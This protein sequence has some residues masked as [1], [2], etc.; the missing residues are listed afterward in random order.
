MIYDFKVK[1]IDGNYVTLDK[2]KGKIMLIVNTA[3]RCG[4]SYQ[5]KELETIYNKYS[6][7]LAILSFPSNQF[8]NQE[9]LNDSEIKEFCSLNHNVTYD[10]FAKIDVNGINEDPLYTYLKN[11][12]RGFLSKDIKWNFTKFLVD[13]KGNVV[14]RFASNVSPYDIEK[15]I[16]KLI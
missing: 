4:F 3:T 6:N 15:Y 1:T 16:E 8:N 2:Y 11:K 12:K 10:T 9:P 5:Y 7:D 14:K 13:K